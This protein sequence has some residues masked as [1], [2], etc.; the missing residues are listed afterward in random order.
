MAQR[1]LFHTINCTKG[2]IIKR[3][4]NVERSEVFWMQNADCLRLDVNKIFYM[5]GN[6]P[7]EI[8]ILYEIH[9]E[10]L[11]INIHYANTLEK[12]NDI[13]KIKMLQ[14]TYDDTNLEQN[15]SLHKINDNTNLE[16]YS[17][18]KNRSLQKINDDTNLEQYDMIEQ[19]S[20]T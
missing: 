20:R 3:L 13:E 6:N 5:Y 7:N 4:Y 18:E 14:N 1:I 11:S 8:T 17:I 10:L 9:H 15:R 12:Q 19:S 16:Q 2:V